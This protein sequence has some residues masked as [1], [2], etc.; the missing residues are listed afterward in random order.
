MDPDSTTNKYSQFG[1]SWESNDTLSNPDDALIVCYICKAKDTEIN[2]VERR[3]EAEANG[4]CVFF[5][6]SK[7]FLL[8]LTCY[9]FCHLHCH[10]NGDITVEVLIDYIQQDNFECTNCQEAKHEQYE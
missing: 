1:H 10:V 7:I 8:C 9:D 6:E 5:A 2:V 4:K 3:Q